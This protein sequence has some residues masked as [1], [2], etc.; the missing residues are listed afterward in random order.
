M[1][2]L[3][4]NELLISCL[5]GWWDQKF[6]LL[7]YLRLFPRQLTG[8]FVLFDWFWIIDLDR[9]VDWLLRSWNHRLVLIRISSASWFIFSVVVVSYASDHFL[10]FFRGA[11]IV[12]CKEWFIL[13]ATLTLALLLLL[14]KLPLLLMTELQVTG[15]VCHTHGSLSYSLRCAR[16]LWCCCTLSSRWLEREIYNTFTIW[17]ILST[18]ELLKMWRNRV[19]ILKNN[20]WVLLFLQK[21]RLAKIVISQVLRVLA[22]SALS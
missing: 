18:I 5:F 21:S 15:F 16:S 11:C 13:L 2:R 10:L 22:R 17:H 9:V 20:H 1:L 4:W 8:V 7:Q 12:K 19:L 6:I 14:H 3:R